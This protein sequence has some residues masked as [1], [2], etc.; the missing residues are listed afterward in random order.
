MSPVAFAP[1]RPRSPPPPPRSVRPDFE[2]EDENEDEDDSDNKRIS[3][4]R[5][6][7]MGHRV[8]LDEW[9]LTFSRTAVRAG[10]WCRRTASAQ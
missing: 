10:R 6:C 8:R 3:Q 9:T 1:P 7:G 4:A 5:N 2:E